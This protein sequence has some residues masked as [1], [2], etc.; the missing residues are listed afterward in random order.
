[1]AVGEIDG[2]IDR[3]GCSDDRTGGGGSGELAVR[4]RR[5]ERDPRQTEQEHD[6]QHATQKTGT[7]KIVRKP[8]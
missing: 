8:S 5:G 1:M 2:T 6:P 4:K 3:A 7:I